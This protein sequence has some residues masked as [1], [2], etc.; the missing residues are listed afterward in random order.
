MNAVPRSAGP[1]LFE[2]RSP[3]PR[4]SRP[5]DHSIRLTILLLVPDQLITFLTL[6]FK[7]TRFGPGLPPTLLLTVLLLDLIFEITIFCPSTVR[8]FR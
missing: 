1:L 3:F 8:L 6:R 2:H 7:I 5:R 4:F